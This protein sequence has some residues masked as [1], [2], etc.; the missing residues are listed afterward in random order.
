MNVVGGH[1]LVPSLGIREQANGLLQ[2]QNFFFFLVLSFLV[3]WDRVFLHSLGCSGTQYVHQIGLDLI[4]INPLSTGIKVMK[5]HCL[6][7]IHE[8]SALDFWWKLHYSLCL[9]YF[10]WFITTWRY[11]LPLFILIAR[12]FKFKE[13]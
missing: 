7:L 5:Y 9:I 10:I 11:F 8:Y 2:Q 4:E 3:F 13:Y 1:L 12:I 6:V